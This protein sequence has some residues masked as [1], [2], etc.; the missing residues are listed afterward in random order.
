MGA[1][2]KHTKEDVTRF[3]NEVCPKCR[4]LESCQNSFSDM[5]EHVPN[6]PK[7]FNFVLGYTSFITEQLEYDLKHPDEVEA[8]HKKNLEIAKKMQDEKKNKKEKMIQKQ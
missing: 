6:C 8:R 7:F 4:C 1:I 2:I 5:G 3:I